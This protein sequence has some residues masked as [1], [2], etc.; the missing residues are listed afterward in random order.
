MEI[1]AASNRVRAPAGRR[2]AGKEQRREDSYNGHDDQHL[3]QRKSL[4]RFR[5]RRCFYT[6]GAYFKILA[7]RNVRLLDRLPQRAVGTG[8]FILLPD[9]ANAKACN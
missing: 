5:L 7:A 2:E 1:L 3:D 9:L 8:L 4:D 6:K